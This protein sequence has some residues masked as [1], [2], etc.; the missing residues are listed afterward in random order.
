MAVSPVC[1]QGQGVSWSL[2]DWSG[3]QVPTSCLGDSAS[4]S[5]TWGCRLRAWLSPGPGLLGP[6]PGQGRP[7]PRVGKA[8]LRLLGG[9]WLDSSRSPP[10]VR[11]SCPVTYRWQ[12]ST[13]RRTGPWPSPQ[14]KTMCPSPGPPWCA[15]R[16]STSV[17]WPTTTQPQRSATA[18]VSALPQ[19]L[20]AGRGLGGEGV[21]HAALSA[22]SS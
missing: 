22:P 20:G 7:G 14:S 10:K 18:P 1:S 19:S 4:Q 5:R 16:Q 9:A 21:A 11:L 12:P 17:P 2:G 13:N 15:S 6:W 3:P 8:G